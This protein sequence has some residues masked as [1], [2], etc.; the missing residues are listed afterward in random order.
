VVPVEAAAELDYLDELETWIG[1]RRAELAAAALA[2]R[3][4]ET[5]LPAPAVPARP[6]RPRPTAAGVL[7]T[8]GAFALVAAGLAF[9]AV[10]W[11]LLGPLGQ[12]LVLVVV[13]VAALAGGWLMAVRIPG[14]ANAL[15]VTGV[16]LLVVAAGFLL[17][18]GSAGPAWVRAAAVAA[19][20][21]AGVALGY[22]QAARQRGA[23]VVTTSFFAV[24]ATVALAFA[25]WLDPPEPS[26][27]GWWLCAVLLVAGTVMLVLDR[28]RDRVASPP[29]PWAGLATASLS[30]GIGVGAMTAAD[31]AGR[32][33]G[34][35]PPAFVG[36]VVLLVGSA[37]LALIGLRTSRWSPWVG[38][39]ALVSITAL[40]LLGSLGEP[41]ARLWYAVLALLLAGALALLAALV[42]P[43]A[44]E[45]RQGLRGLVRAAAERLAT[46]AVGIA[47]ALVM[48]VGAAAPIPTCTGWYDEFCVDEAT[49]AWLRELHPWWAGVLVGAA[50]AVLA[51]VAVLA[52]R[53]AAGRA[54]DLPLLAA[55]AVVLGW[56]ALVAG[57]SA[58]RGADA[59]VVVPAYA[60]AL[61]VGGLG[62]L[63]VLGLARWTTWTIWPAAATASVG[64]L[65]AW[66]GQVLVGTDALPELL[67]VLLALPLA[68]AGY[69]T[70]RRTGARA[71]SWT[72]IGPALCAVLTPS[73]LAVVGD[74]LDRAF[75]DRDVQPG[76]LLR[77]VAVLGIGVLLAA[78]GAR[79]HLSAVFWPGVVAVAAVVAV[80]L[81]EISTEVPQWVW[82][83]VAGALLMLVGARWEWARRQ[84]HRTREWSATLR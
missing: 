82:L 70:H 12:L 13:G 32:L 39:A 3:P 20:G 28:V 72:T 54:A 34:S 24:L 76:A 41:A 46:I 78:L 75:A 84:G 7:L 21:C 73:V 65:V 80:T 43:G 71:S 29:V 5:S 45:H 23:A 51:G 17:S 79:A 62:T 50:A 81:V 55:G 56:V 26:W 40:L 8:V 63:L 74:T 49:T 10:A 27:A 11:D 69:L 35:V 59:D 68:V 67:G 25:P 44:S 14:T 37:V 38:S 4:V 9:T 16:L 42:D 60:A 64:V 19:A 6:A 83:S 1:V 58:M 31:R 30:L 33:V 47:V 36:G 66:N 18:S 15:S 53:R 77:E 2:P 22:R 48:A 61:V 57:D 52:L